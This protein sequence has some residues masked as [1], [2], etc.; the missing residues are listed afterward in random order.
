MAVLLLVL[1]SGAVW[2]GLDGRQPGAEIT[3]VSRASEPLFARGAAT[4][5]AK[6]LVGSWW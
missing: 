6:V 5:S 2:V 4:W 1:C 3:D